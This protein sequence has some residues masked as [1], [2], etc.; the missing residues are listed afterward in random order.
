MRQMNRLNNK[1]ELQQILY[2]IPFF[3]NL[4]NEEISDLAQVVNIIE[5]PVGYV[6][7][8]EGECG[9]RF[10]VIVEGEV[11]IIKALGT[12]EESSF[13]VRGPGE[14]LGEM[15]LL[16]WDGK[17]T[18]SAR[19]C[20]GVR[21][22]EITRQHFDLLLTRHPGL[23]FEMMR[24]MSNRLTNTQEQAI[25]VLREKNQQLQTAYDELKAAQV[26]L[27]EKERLEKELQVAREIQLSILPST[28][29]MVAGYELGALIVPAR[30]VGGDF[31]D[32]FP[33]GIGHLGVLIGDVTDK[34]IPA[35]IY[36]AQ[37]RALVRAKAAPEISPIQTLDMVNKVL[38]DTNDSGMF[39]TV[40][41][42]NLDLATGKMEYA[43]AGH[44]VPL[45]MDPSGNSTTIPFNNGAPLGI[46]ESPNLDQQ[47]VQIRPGE[48]LLLYT[49]GVTDGLN[50]ISDSTGTYELQGLMCAGNGLG[51]QEFC[52]YISQSI[53]ERQNG[54]QQFDDVT[55][56]AVKAI[57]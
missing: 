10:F 36:M 57:G 21:L 31:F 51:A 2:K 40:L 35:A 52:E 38:L 12:Q 15:S 48:M 4:S 16:N 17:R 6:L 8:N 19:S 41:Y 26:Q 39:V 37:A 24:E 1:S 28:L 18:A 30:A 9:D 5:A 7:L 33:L 14:Y 47:Q 46:F 13:G 45:L 55:I 49:D 42:G 56:L 20:S 23:V 32:I 25:Q 29:P 44:E 54:S 43:R 50:L 22:I 27:I 34:G 11:E 53:V 3:Q